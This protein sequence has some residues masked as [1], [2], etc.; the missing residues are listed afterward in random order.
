M[1][2]HLIPETSHSPNLQRWFDWMAQDHSPAGLALLLADEV[3]FKSPVVHTP[4]V[5]KPITMGYL[6]AAGQTLGNDCFRYTRVFDC[7]TRAVLEFET[8]MD[9]VQV[10]GIDMIEWNGE[11]Q[12]TDFKVMVRPLKAIQAVHAAMGAMLARMKA[13]A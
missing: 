4:Q 6:L 13:G 7:G 2:K 1:S 8:E 5:G 3:V 12:I 11:G 9:G 10:N